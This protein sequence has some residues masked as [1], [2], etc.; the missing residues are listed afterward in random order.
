MIFKSTANLAGIGP[1]LGANLI[2]NDSAYAPIQ[3]AGDKFWIMDSDNAS[4]G[5]AV[6]NRLSFGG[7]NLDNGAVFSSPFGVY[8]E[9]RYNVAG[10]PL[11]TGHDVLLTTTSTAPIP[12]PATLL[13]VGTAALGFFGYLRRRRMK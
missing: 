8:Y 12:E 4:V 5:A 13:L 1:T 9:I 2:I 7:A 11:G 6:S 3:Q 10:D